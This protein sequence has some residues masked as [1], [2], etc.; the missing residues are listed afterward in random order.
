MNIMMK[1]GQKRPEIPKPPNKIQIQIEQYIK[2]YENRKISPEQISRNIGVSLRTVKS[3]IKKYYKR[4]EKIPPKYRDLPNKIAELL[5]CGY[6]EKQ[7]KKIA[8]QRNIIILDED[9]E[10]A[11]ELLHIKKKK[12][13]DDEI[14]I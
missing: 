1:S 8:Y 4:V 5:K 11:K 12:E 14:P 9:F 2:D 13:D 3:H 6:T 10:Q 7:I